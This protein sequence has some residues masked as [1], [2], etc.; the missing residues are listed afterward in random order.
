M[1]ALD[2]S[3]SARDGRLKPIPQRGERCFV[4][5]GAA[6]PAGRPDGGAGARADP[7]RPE[8]EPPQAAAPARRLQP[9]AGAAACRRALPRPGHHHQGGGQPG[10]L[11]R[12]GLRRQPRGG[13]RRRGR[14]RAPHRPGQRGRC[15]R[16]VAGVLQP[17]QGR[18]GRRAACAGPAGPG[19]GAAFTAARPARRAATGPP[20]PG[21]DHPPACAPGRRTWSHW[22]GCPKCRSSPACRRSTPRYRS[23]A[24]SS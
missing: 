8:P 9:P 19:A 18:A 20:P 21:I 14:G 17:R 10:G 16:A 24:I 1:T 12:G 13:A 15:Q 6:S 3:V 7:P 11:P 23:S 5:G 2:G 4:S 22:H